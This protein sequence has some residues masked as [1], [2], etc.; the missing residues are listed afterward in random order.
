MQEDF[1]EQ[2]RAEYIP[3]EEVS[4]LQNDFRFLLLSDNDKKLLATGIKETKQ[5]RN[6]MFK[7]DID[8]EPTWDHKYKQRK[9]K[10]KI[11]INDNFILAHP[12]IKPNV[13]NKD[14]KERM[15]R[16]EKMEM[17]KVQE[18]NKGNGS[19]YRE[20]KTQTVKES[21][22]I[23]EASKKKRPTRKEL[24]QNKV[25]LTG[26]IQQQTPPPYENH[27]LN[28]IYST[29]PI[30]DHGN[31]AAQMF[32]MVP[33]HGGDRCRN[34]RDPQIREEL[35]KKKLQQ[36]KNTTKKEEKHD[37]EQPRPNFKEGTQVKPRIRPTFKEKQPYANLSKAQYNAQRQEAKRKI[38]ERKAEDA[39]ARSERIA[40]IL[41]QRDE[42]I[43]P[44]KK[45]NNIKQK[46]QSMKRKTKRDAF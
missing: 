28:K 6:E 20:L 33:T 2:L 32:G 7:D 1:K 4:G 14:K 45:Q 42:K 8:A 23:P 40:I 31:W 37:Q 46:E 19:N 21:P 41:Q 13:Q 38:A 39:K 30:A 3:V 16:K 25:G 24:L 29:E 35:N 44:D 34:R 43:S 15:T 22:R 18:Q 11:D 17:E 27:H 26:K 36:N 9:W 10:G 12:F 5:K